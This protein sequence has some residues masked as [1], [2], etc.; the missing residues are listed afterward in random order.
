MVNQL[1]F[2][3]SLIFNILFYSLSTIIGV[4]FFPILISKPLTIKITNI[5][6]KIT[7]YMLNSICNIKIDIQNLESF[8]KGQVLF[9]VRHE[10]VLE[11]IL[12]LAYFPNVKYVL[13]KELLYIPFYGLFVWRCGHIII[14]RNGRASSIYLML[15]KIKN[16]LNKN[17]SIVIFPHGTRVKASANVEIKSGI[18]ALYKHL[19]I[20]IIPVHMST[21]EFWDKKGF[22]KRPGLV[23]V[24]FYKPI[25]NSYK[26]IDFIKLLNSKLN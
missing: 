2:I 14:N 25:S 18:Y 4:I 13:K 5:W 15:K 7:I 22:I 20:K 12:F 16:N 1:I 26:K 3:K 19:N 23:K 9:A 10:S 21:A 24:K 6:A 8:T 11:T 17:E